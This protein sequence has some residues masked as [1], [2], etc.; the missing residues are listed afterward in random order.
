GQAVAELRTVRAE[1]KRL[2]QDARTLAQR[3][4]LLSF[5]TDEIFSARLQAGEDEELEAERV[6]L[7]NA[8]TLLQ[9]AQ[10]SQAI[11]S[12]GDGDMPAVLDLVSEAVARLER[13]ARIDPSMQVS[14]DEAQALLEQLGE[15]A[16]TLEDYG[17]QLEFNPERLEEVEERIELIQ[18]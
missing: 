17:E 8:E 6:R 2:R 5:Q 14:A 18:N 9:L 1:L 3:V 10:S 4:D 7:G 11:L 15:L 16:R 13:L 12:V